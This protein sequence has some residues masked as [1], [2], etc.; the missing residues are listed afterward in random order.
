MITVK[1]LL[2]VKTKKEPDKN[3]IKCCEIKSAFLSLFI[4]PKHTDGSVEASFSLL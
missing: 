3:V 4:F 1:V 2:T